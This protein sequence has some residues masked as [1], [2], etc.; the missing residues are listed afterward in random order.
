MNLRYGFLIAASGIVAANWFLTRLLE[1]QGILT[2]WTWFVL[3]ALLI[4]AV[5][6]QA[7]D[8]AFVHA[9]VPGV[10][11]TW[12]PVLGWFLFWDVSFDL[13]YHLGLGLGFGLI[14]GGLAAVS[15]A[16]QKSTNPQP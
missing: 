11:G 10:V 8:A 13:Q 2:W 7:R 14:V 4:V 1:R 16:L 15:V 9:L 3:G 12:I 6:R 5:R